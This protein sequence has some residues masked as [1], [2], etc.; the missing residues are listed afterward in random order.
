MSGHSSGLGRGTRAAAAALCSVLA[1]LGACHRLPASST[2]KVMA[3]AGGAPIVLVPTDLPRAAGVRSPVNSRP[4]GCLAAAPVVKKAPPPPFYLSGR[5]GL[6]VAQVDPVTLEPVRAVGT[7][8]NSVFPLASAYKQTVLWA[9][10]REFDAGRLSPNERFDVTR[11]NQSLGSYPFDGSNVKTLSVRMIA[12]S[13]NTAT[14]ILHRRVGLQRVQD[15]A[16]RLGLCR[17][18]VILPTRDWWVAQAGLS[19]TFNG[20]TRWASASGRDR[21]RLA[22]LIDDDARAYRADYVQSKLDRYFETRHAPADDLR[23]HNLSTPY[24]LSTL[25]AHEFLRPGLSPRAERWQREVMALGYGRAALRWG[26]HINVFGGKGG[27]GWGIL[28]YSGFFQ[29]NDGRQ[30]VYAFM[31]HGADQTYTMPNTRRAFAWINAGVEQVLGP[32]PRPEQKL[33]QKR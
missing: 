33:R 31:Q 10:L 26:P 2:G 28:T 14:D 1:L 19:A 11:E 21:Q 9:L 12:S 32:P 7:N 27:N 29:T 16:D 24:E 4:D 15:V 25:L 6:W 20:T 30:V 8:P 5:L 13:D 18:R 23:V 3:P 22:A 17:T